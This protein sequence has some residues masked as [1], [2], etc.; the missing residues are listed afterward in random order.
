[1]TAGLG[2]AIASVLVWCVR[3]LG[4]VVE[5]FPEPQ[6][7]RPVVVTL[8]PVFVIP[9]WPPVAGAPAAPPAV[10]V[11]P[12]IFGAPLP[13]VRR[14]P[15]SWPDADFGPHSLPLGR[16]RSRRGRPVASHA[17]PALGRPPGFVR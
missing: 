7:E 1:M 14:S 6:L 10:V 16:Q 11:R 8:L 5:G 9:P 12:L 13:I 3:M 2:S 17:R 4:V 15:E